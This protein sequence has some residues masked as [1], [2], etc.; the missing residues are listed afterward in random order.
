MP[1]QSYHMIKTFRKH[2]KLQNIIEAE[3]ETADK[4]KNHNRISWNFRHEFAF[5]VL[6]GRYISPFDYPLT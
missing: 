5:K 6:I 1:A 3:N 4:K 2:C